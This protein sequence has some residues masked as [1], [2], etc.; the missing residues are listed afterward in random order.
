MQTT[1][2]STSLMLFSHTSQCIIH[3]CVGTDADKLNIRI[4][5]MSC[6]IHCLCRSSTCSHTRGRYFGYYDRINIR[7]PWMFD[8]VCSACVCVHGCADVRLSVCT[9]MFK[10]VFKYCT[11]YRINVMLY[12]V[13]LHAFGLLGTEH[14]APVLNVNMRDLNGF[15]RSDGRHV[16]TNIVWAV[17][18]VL[19]ST[20][21]IT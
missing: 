3:A 19:A 6:I 20:T 7:S 14:C 11:G 17:L 12:H 5:T 1:H 2:S 9:L 16:S 15:V 8:I 21:Y 18:F 4:Y 10:C 13:Y